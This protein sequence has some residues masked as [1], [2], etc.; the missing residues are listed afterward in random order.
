MDEA[1][2][3]VAQL[4]RG[5]GGRFWD[6]IEAER[7]GTYPEE[8]LALG[9]RQEAAL[10]LAW[11]GDPEGLAGLRVL[12]VGCGQGRLAL[13]LSAAGARVLGVDLLPRFAPPALAAARRHELSLVV[14]DFRD[15]L[16]D[17][18]PRSDNKEPETVEAGREE[19]RPFAPRRRPAPRDEAATAADPSRAGFDV[20]LLR[21]VIQD[22]PPD[23]QKRV[24]RALAPAPARRVMLTLRQESGWSLWLRGMWPEGLGGSADPVALLRAIHLA[25]PYRLTRQREIRRRNFST[26]AAE[27]TRMD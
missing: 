8:N 7:P 5:P 6:R 10:L 3:R 19:P 9:R 2:R 13:R 22:Y 21:E 1:A 23:E 18:L 15:S 12:D 14:G 26:W 27:L 11:M 25:T 24:L 16:A 20:L 4:Y 17:L